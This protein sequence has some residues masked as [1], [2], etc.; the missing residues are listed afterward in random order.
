M[1]LGAA[2]Y[3][4]GDFRTLT[5]RTAAGA[6]ALGLRALNART[7]DPYS[8]TRAE[9]ARFRDTLERRGLAAGQTAGNYGGGLVSEDGAERERAVRFVQEMCRLTQL[10]GAPTTYLRPG[11]LNRRG[12]WLPHPRNRSPAVFDRLVDSARRVC[13]AA[14]GEGVMV[15][16]EGGVVSPLYSPA[17][18]EAFIAAVDSPAL[19][20]NQDPVNLIGSLEQ[21]YDTGALIADSFD[22]LGRRTVSAHVKDFTLVEA[23]LPHFEEAEIGAGMLDQAAYLTRLQAVRPGVHAYIEHLATERFAAAVAA[24]TAISRSAGVEWD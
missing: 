17:R 11:S 7:D 15:A 22:R 19:G 24:V 20:F 10:L 9:A 16:V 18:I 21:A 14:E 12:A 8:V 5:D 3:H 6:A 2:D 1:L 23:L 4:K 13:S